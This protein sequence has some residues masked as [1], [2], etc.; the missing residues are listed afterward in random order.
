MQNPAGRFGADVRRTLAICFS[1]FF[2]NGLMTMMMGSVLPDLKAAYGLTDTQ[3]GLM[4]AAHSAGNLAACLLGGLVQLRLGSRRA[5]TL[6]SVAAALGYTM[7][8]LSGNPAWLIAAFTLSG[9]GRGSIS[10]FNNGT[11]TR[12]TQGSPSASNLLH[13]FF[14]IGAISAPLVFLLLSRV[15]GWQAAAFATA[16]LGLTVSLAFTRLP[17][18]ADKPAAAGQSRQSFAFLRDPA[19]LIFGGMMFFYLCAEYS[20]NGWLVTYLQS[21]PALLAQFAAAGGD[22]RAALVTYSQAMATLFWAV[23]LAG[24]LLSAVLSRRV[25]Q[26]LMMLIGSAGALGFFLLLLLSASAWPATAAVA[27]L[28]FCF[29]GICPMIYS[30]ASSI[31]NRYPLGVSGI[32]A[33]GSVGAILMPALVGAVADAYGFAGG[34]AA[35]LGGMVALLLLCAL[36]Y[37]RGP[38]AARPAQAPTCNP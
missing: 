19:Y 9:V 24:R 38:R 11:V 3:G 14:A 32:L 35:I 13:S 7:L 27:G 28:G 33:I 30:D 4:L 22:A 31:T 37:A 16:A 5:I 36:N 26:K 20:V 2:F 12:V 6:L 15:A 8:P 10:N 1:S 18:A 34:M 29:S 17:A 23:I 21:R 25:P